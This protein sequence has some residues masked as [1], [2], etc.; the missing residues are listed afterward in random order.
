[1]LRVDEKSHF[2][3]IRVLGGNKISWK[4]SK[5]SGGSILLRVVRL[6]VSVWMDIFGGD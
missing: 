1:M 5:P 6:P 2:F 3:Y 4:L